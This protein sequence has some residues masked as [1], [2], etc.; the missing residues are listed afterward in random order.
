MLGILPWTTAAMIVALC[1][2]V[3]ATV[4]QQ[5]WQSLQ[6]QG[7]HMGTLRLAATAHIWWV[8][9]AAGCRDLAECSSK[10]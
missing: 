10:V 2:M 1:Q 9:D 6:L 8:A 3:V 7:F 4:T 5:W